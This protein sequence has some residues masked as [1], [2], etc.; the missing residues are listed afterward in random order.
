[1]SKRGFFVSG[2]TSE[3]RLTTSRMLGD[4][5]LVETPIALTVS[6]SDGSARLTR[7]CTR[8]CAM[9]RFVPS[10]KV[11]VRLYPPSLV[12][13]D[14]MYNMFSTPITCCSIGAATVSRTTD[15]LAPGYEHD[16]WTVGG[17]ISG[18]W[19]IGRILTAASPASRITSEMTTPKT[20]RSMKNFAI[21]AGSGA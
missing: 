18:Y 2:L 7:F 19:A 8:T 4:F 6:G 21:L 13:C 14:D 16:T 12:H 1:W 17:V 9:S 3:N 11:T 20:G 15:A 5:F 10:L